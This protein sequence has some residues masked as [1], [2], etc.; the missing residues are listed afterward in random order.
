MIFL[1]P[2]P[3]KGVIAANPDRLLISV[4]LPLRG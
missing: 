2:C 4:I 3:L 1:T